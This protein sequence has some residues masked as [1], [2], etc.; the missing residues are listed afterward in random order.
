MQKLA[1]AMALAAGFLMVGCPIDLPVDPPDT[2]YLH[3]DDSGSTFDIVNGEKI[4]VYL[5]GNPTTGYTWQVMLDGLLPALTFDDVEYIPD[6]TGI[7][8]SGGHYQFVF[9]A[10]KRGCGTI[11]IGLFGPG[12]DTPDETFTA[13]IN[14]FG[15]GDQAVM[16]R[17]SDKDNGESRALGIGGMVLIKLVENPSTGYTWQVMDNG[18]PVLD[19]D[20]MRSGFQAESEA[21]GS[22]GFHLFFFDAVAAGTTTV[23]LGHFAPGANEPEATYTLTV[24]VG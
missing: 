8:G 3:K 1:M 18:G 20:E 16:V 4:T 15:R 10:E 19:P 7:E 17:A 11:N 14:V 13:D 21:P 6:S 9:E 23:E 22:P 2:M 5:T 12:A 24:T